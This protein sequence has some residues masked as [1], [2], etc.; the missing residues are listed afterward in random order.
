MGSDLSIVSILPPL[1]V[2]FLGYLTHRVIFSLSCG[3]I[4]A[5]L[6]AHNFSV[7]VA[8]Q[9]ILQTLWTNLITQ[10]N[11]HIFIFLLFL[12]II[13]VMLQ[14]SGGAYAY[15]EFV[16][17]RVRTKRG[18]ETASLI[19]SLGLF[20][21]D[22][23]SSL[24]V[25]SVMHPLTD[26]KRIPKAKA[27]FLVD[28][29]ASPLPVFCPFSGWVAAILGFLHENGIS[30][31][32]AETTMV[33]GTPFQAYVHI[34]P[35]VFYSFL[36]VATTWFIVR[37]KISF[38]IMHRHERIASETGDL[39]GG[40]KQCNLKIRERAHNP[41]HTTLLEFFVP[42]GIMLASFILG[43]GF[44]GSAATGLM[45]GGLITV[46]TCLAFFLARTRIEL[47]QI[48][49]VIREGVKLMY[50]CIIVLL[51]AWTLGDFLR[52]QLFTGEYLASLMLG[53]V[54]VTTLPMIVFF[55]GCVVTCATGS[56][57]G[58]AA[59]LFPI[60]IPLVLSMTS[61]VSTPTLQ[62]VPMLFPVLGAALS[63]CLAGNHISPI[64]DTTIMSSLS[65]RAN[66]KCHIYSQLQY[67]TPGIVVT[68]ASFW[69]C[70]S[71]VQYNTTLAIFLPILSGIIATCAILK[72]YNGRYIR[73]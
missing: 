29:M 20:L 41:H 65:T 13:I 16:K 55:A 56:S 11:L 46:V 48:P 63:G 60:V 9:D 40:V 66:L 71:L 14:Y 39:Y 27:A 72:L 17:K 23:L 73:V 62:D 4:L 47:K 42:I 67:A 70:G 2:L 28:S 21:D 31:K 3:I 43:V 57:W 25:G 24:T 35:Y 44:S 33:I 34:L 45:L 69:L 59:M 52:N 22:Y 37:Y 15:T 5:A 51:L 50:G 68:G 19:L 6:L 58:S 12:G 53:S 30:P 1:L 10:S 38:G 32:Y 49:E 26:S 61:N 54:E 64:A 18:A 8:G 36:A 7:V